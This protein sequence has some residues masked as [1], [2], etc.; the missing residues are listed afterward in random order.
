MMYQNND[1]IQKLKNE[2]AKNEFEISSLF[3]NKNKN[4]I[5]VNKLEYI[6]W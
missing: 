2:N 4:L 5:E 1:L 3:Q 6:Y